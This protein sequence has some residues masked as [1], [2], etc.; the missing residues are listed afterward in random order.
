MQCCACPQ[1]V[2][3]PSSCLPLP[4]LLQIPADAIAAALAQAQAADSDSEDEGGFTEAGS[5]WGGDE[6]GVPTSARGLVASQ[7]RARRACLGSC[8]CQPPLPRNLLD[9]AVHTHT[10]AHAGR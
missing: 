4:P 6:V 1:R 7:A 5:M 9:R 10:R 3:A 2:C 8:R